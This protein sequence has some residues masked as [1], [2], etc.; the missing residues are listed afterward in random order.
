MSA[1]LVMLLAA[2]VVSGCGA[3][4]SKPPSQATATQSATGPQKGGAVVYALAPLV[5]I[6]WYLPIGAI[7]YSTTLTDQ[8]SRMMYKPLFHVGPNAKIDFSRSIASSVTWNA[9]G[10]VYTVQMNPKWH[11][12]DGQPVTANDVLFDWKMIQAASAKNAPSPWPYNLA[13]SG[14]IPN[15]IK[16]FRVV[17]AH[18]FQVTLTQ[19]V[20]QQ[21]F[22]YD[23][24]SQFRPLPAQA[25]DKYKGNVSEDLAYLARH[26]AD[27]TFFKVV[28]GP[29]QLSSVVP[30]STW[31]FVPNPKYD[32]HK[33]YLDKFIF[34][35][36]TSDSAEV[37]Q[38]RTGAVQVG[39]LPATEYAVRTQ[40]T[41]DKFFT[42]VN[43]GFGRDLI[44]FANPTTGPII[45]QLP[46]RQALAMGLDQSG[47][48]HTL[49]DGQASYGTGPVPLIPPTFLDPKL[50]KPAYGYNLA[51]GR[52]LLEKNGWHMQNGVMTNA[53]GQKLDFTLQYV[54]GDTTTQALAQLEQ[55]DWAKEG[56]K[57]TLEPLTFADMLHNHV[58]PAAWEIQT[59]IAFSLGA[60][61][62]TGASFLSTT[63]AYN[64]YKY[65]SSE[66]NSLIAA[67]HAPH[68]TAAGAQRALDAYELYA[69]QQLPQL[70]APHPFNLNEVERTVHGVV[71]TLNNFA[72]TIS[73]QYWW[74]GQ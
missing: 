26:G 42:S 34:A 24:L 72:G 35:F 9:N 33:P 28:D 46:V 17:N 37:G 23:G 39:Y 55:T 27:P 11:W 40:L 60:S 19:P 69:A 36:E 38:L 2:L 52:A 73:P 51:A 22:E 30:N 56:I 66:M 62:P 6:T 49:Y 65:S 53:Q 5:K 48:I 1:A 3:T 41:N 64:F 68:K 25:W 12:S 32:G 47:I 16:S 57:V 8:A 71:S 70:W 7:R 14:G 44:N 20:S 29:W 74:V 50:E 43:Y 13:G 58:H 67:T 54:S 21:W 4:A 63:G 15:L 10:T 59:G 45:Q 18:E 31:T 61:Y